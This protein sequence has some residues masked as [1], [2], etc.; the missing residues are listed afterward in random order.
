MNNAKN[1]I[2]P[3]LLTAVII[4]VFQVP[5][6][7]CQIK[8][9]IMKSESSETQAGESNPSDLSS[10]STSKEEQAASDEEKESKLVYFDY[11]KIKIESTYSIETKIKNCN[12]IL[13]Y[14]GNLNV[15]GEIENL[16]NSNKTSLVI[17][18][19]FY[20]K[21]GEI[22]FS[23]KLPVSINYLR[24]SSK[25]PFS[26]V[27]K[28]S[29]RYIDISKIKI[30]INYKDYYKLLEGNAIVRKETFYYR[31]NILHV[32]GKI[33]NIGES[34]IGNLLLLATFY[35]DKDGVVFIKQCYLPER[36]LP[37]QEEENF[38]LEV[39]LSKYAP[40]FTHYDF[41]VFFEDSVKMP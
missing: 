18:F 29:Y 20:D 41:E 24:V 37:A 1:K 36:E 22:I 33:V 14:F 13:D 2:M 31:D 16:S 38:S 39:L 5:I 7:S 28:D 32:D 6:I 8:D 34:S 15:L 19:D 11:K 35:N 40:D 10:S 4:I 27:V 26:Y 23:D 30:G 21:K 12:L 25:L 9:Y 3:L 17:T